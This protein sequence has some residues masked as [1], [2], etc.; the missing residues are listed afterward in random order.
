LKEVNIE[1]HVPASLVPEK[2]PAVLLDRRMDEPQ[3][4]SGSFCRELNTD[5]SPIQ[6]II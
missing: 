1:I 6:P 5:S 2:D 4:L 3:S